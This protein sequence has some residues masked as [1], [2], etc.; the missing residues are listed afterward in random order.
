MHLR[1]GQMYDITHCVLIVF[2]VEKKYNIST[3]FE[4]GAPRAAGFV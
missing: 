4:D 1:I 2:S 3:F